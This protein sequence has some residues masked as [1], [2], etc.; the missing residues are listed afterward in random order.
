MSKSCIPEIKPHVLCRCC[1]FHIVGDTSV[2]ILTF[3]GWKLIW[4]THTMCIWLEGPDKDSVFRGVWLSLSKTES[5]AIHPLTWAMFFFF[6]RSCFL[7][8][9]W[10]NLTKT[11]FARFYCWVFECWILKMH[12]TKQIINS[13]KLD[14]FNTFIICA[15]S[16]FRLTKIH[17]YQ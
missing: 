12:W 13:S 11:C 10:D 2:F 6:N 15:S 1:I 14:I 3:L 7:L 9:D 4:W 17:F 5:Q 16:S 8:W